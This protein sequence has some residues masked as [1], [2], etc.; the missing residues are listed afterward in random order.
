MYSTCIQHSILQ[1]FWPCYGM[2]IWVQNSNL[3]LTVKEESSNSCFIEH[4]FVCMLHWIIVCCL[5]PLPHIRSFSQIKDW[6]LFHIH[7]ILACIKVKIPNDCN[8]WIIQIAL[9]IAPLRKQDIHY[10]TSTFHK[11]KCQSG[12]TFVCPASTL[13][14]STLQCRPVS[15]LHMPRLKEHNTHLWFFSYSLHV[16]I[17]VPILFYQIKQIYQVIR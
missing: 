10:I 11:P 15:I 1:N 12:W 16:Y 8:C 14:N 7:Q 2:Y 6:K 13:L 9:W 3:I 4:M 17:H 5:V